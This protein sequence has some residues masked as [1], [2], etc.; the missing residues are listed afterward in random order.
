MSTLLLFVLV[1]AFGGLLTLGGLALLVI[2]LVLLVRRPKAAAPQYSAPLPAAEGDEF[3]LPSDYLDAP[4]WVEGVAEQSDAEQPSAAQAATR[5][6]QPMRRRAIALA[7]VGA[8]V[9]ALGIT[10]VLSTSFYLFG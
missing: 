3:G 4:Q 6:D 9:L 5:A 1:I 2:G 10:L 7:A 8:L